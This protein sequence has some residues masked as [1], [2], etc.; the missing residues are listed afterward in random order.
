M[1]G[2]ADMLEAPDRAISLGG[3]GWL[4]PLEE[5]GRKWTDIAR[6][7]N[8]LSNCGK[9]AS[10][11]SLRAF[12]DDKLE[13]APVIEVFST[14]GLDPLRRQLLTFRDVYAGLPDRIRR[15]AAP[16]SAF[17][18]TPVAR[19]DDTPEPTGFRDDWV[20]GADPGEV[21]LPLSLLAID[22]A[23]TA[24]GI[25]VRFQTSAGASLTCEAGALWP[26]S[27]DDVRPGLI[28]TTLGGT[29]EARA[30]GRLPFRSGEL[31]AN[32][33]AGVAAE[34]MYFHRPASPD[35]IFAAEVARILP[36]LPD[37]FALGSVWTAMATDGLQGLILA[38]NGHA[39]VDLSLSV[40]KSMDLPKVLSG[41]LAITG[42]VLLKR[43]AA[44]TLSIRSVGSATLGRQRL[45]IALSRNKSAAGKWGL[46]LGLELDVSP[47][48]GRIC[49]VLADGLEVWSTELA[50][51]RPFLNPGGWI[52]D[53]LAR[54]LDKL[55]AGLI[56]D[57]ALRKALLQDLGLVSGGD[58]TLGTLLADKVAEKIGA[59]AGL[60]FGNTETVA[61]EA[62]GKLT[63]A[64]PTLLRDDARTALQESVKALIV[65]FQSAVEE[66][67]RSISSS[68]K[69]G[70]IDKALRSAGVRLDKKI[71]DAAAAFT[72][73]RDFVIRFD[74]LLRD[75]V[76]K[77]AEGAKQKIGVQL[78][79]EETRESDIDMEIVGMIDRCTPEAEALYRALLRGRLASLQELLIAGGS[80]P[81]FTL[82]EARSS[83]RR[84]S[85]VSRKI[86]FAFVGF[87]SELSATELLSGEAEVRLLGNGDISVVARGEL[88][89]SVQ[90]PREGRTLSLLSSYE[91]LL[92]RAEDMDDN[93]RGAAFRR[94]LSLG[95]VASHRDKS[96]RAG[97]VT[98]F[99]SGLAD[100]G[101]I[102]RERAR[103]AGEIY[104]SWSASGGSDARHPAGDIVIS[105]TLENAGLQQLLATGRDI[106][107]ELT[108]GAP[109]DK[110]R[111]VFECALDAM[112]RTKR[113]SEPALLR[114]IRDA[115]RKNL[116]RINRE[117]PDREWLL[118]ILHF[119]RQRG[120]VPVGKHNRN[121]DMVSINEGPSMR[122]LTIAL[123]AMNA[124]AD[125]LQLMAEIHDAEPAGL[126][127]NSGWSEADY[128]DR[129]K[130][131]AASGRE[132]MGLNTHWIFWSREGMSRKTVAFMLT[133]ISLSTGRTMDEVIAGSLG[134]PRFL[135][136]MTG[137]SGANGVPVAV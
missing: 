24:D 96:L 72:G 14:L 16:V 58:A 113:I 63:S 76:A 8:G 131:L 61:E 97:E 130:D 110:T 34:L 52:R 35:A 93:G 31:G 116:Y 101:L 135:I 132:W 118:Q 7:L 119:E 53:N 64:L 40:G 107:R 78:A 94:S 38:I 109:L 28:Q 43:K 36:D 77:V 23:G 59:V 62:I 105:M 49:D 136:T 108:R 87:D 11:E 56:R 127:G 48:V 4:K 5:L 104:E 54:E 85:R 99:L 15:L 68:A 88:T 21:R 70:D 84:F 81:G 18:E 45:L 74:T 91:L 137:R 67:L 1:P 57:E 121:V 71:S 30:G 20:D 6:R 125:M 27:R 50:R 66:E 10:I 114:N 117:V 120:G 103:H 37:P 46:G 102:R 82:D 39:E 65:G 95:L 2:L 98:G 13:T 115:R 51:I 41:N 29:L 55:A 26:Y 126:T 17:S 90:G 129:E 19:S 111:V 12:L 122:D 32:G 25:D 47:L 79:F 133:L 124:F 75:T 60:A 89:K 22:R 128:R 42:K 9:I 69:P 106:R 44:Y 92:A 3:A 80:A 33:A 112:L 86:G 123:R 100:H 134:D 73:L 83:I